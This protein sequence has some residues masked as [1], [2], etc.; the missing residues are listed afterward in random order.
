MRGK[1]LFSACIIAFAT[2]GLP[3]ASAYGSTPSQHRFRPL[4]RRTATSG[5]LFCKQPQATFYCYFPQQIRAAYAVQPLLHAG[6]DGTGRTIVIVDAFQDPTIRSDLSRFDSITGIPDPPSL[7][8][9]APY[10]LTP[11]DVTNADQV[12]WSGEIALDVEWAHAIAPGARIKLVL[13]PSDADS[14]IVNALS[15]V[16]S[17]HLGDVVSMSFGEAEACLLPQLMAEQTQIF[18]QGVNQ[19][20]TFAAG[21]GDVGAAQYPCTGAKGWIDAASTPASDPDVTGV[22]GTD[23]LADLTTGQY[24]SESVWNEPKYNLAGGG[25]FSNVFQRPPYQNNANPNPMRGVPDVAWSASLAHGVYVYWSSSDQPYHNWIFTGTSVGTPQWAALLAIADQ[26]ARRDLG[27]VNPRLYQVAEATNFHD[28]IVGN[29][30]FP[31]VQGFN[32]ASGWD[33][34]SGLGSPVAVNLVTALTS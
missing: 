21:S 9:V 30:D 31:P 24:Q 23:L 22:G 8:I 6:T 18:S 26:I 13:S 2:A 32:A 20:M 11:Y 16:V 7:T 1:L 29:N 10:G 19:G 14:D 27:N 4:S 25:N 28:V 15:Y 34:A 3:S 12:G 33:A 5:T 17:K